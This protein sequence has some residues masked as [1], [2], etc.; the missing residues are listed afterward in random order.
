MDEKK[1]KKKQKKRRKKRRRRK[2]GSLRRKGLHNLNGRGPLFL[3]RGGG[4]SW[5]RYP[6][7]KRKKNE[8]TFPITR[9]KLPNCQLPITKC[10]MH[11][12]LLHYRGTPISDW[13]ICLK[14]EKIQ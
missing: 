9:A 2:D 10:T 6:H 8:K 12:L 11:F 3:G 13:N 5:P 14:K 7:K 1:K 4:G